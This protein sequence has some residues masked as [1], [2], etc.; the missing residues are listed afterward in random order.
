[1]YTISDIIV[2]T[3]CGTAVYTSGGSASYPVSMDAAL[4]AVALHRFGYLAAAIPA[5]GWKPMYTSSLIK[6]GFVQLGRSP[7]RK[8]RQLR[9]EQSV[10]MGLS[11]RG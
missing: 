10:A 7:R 5:F 4:A 11:G 6:G 1:M 8:R 9:E 2:G 3:L